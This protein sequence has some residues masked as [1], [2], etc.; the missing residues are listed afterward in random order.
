MQNRTFRI[1]FVATLL[2]TP[3]PGQTDESETL[4]EYAMHRTDGPMKMDG[5][6]DEPAWLAAPVMSPF[7]FPWYKEGRK[8]QSV[9]KMLWDDEYVYIGHICEDAHITA[10]TEEHD[11]PVSKDDC[12]EIMVTPDP[13][14]PIFYFNVEWNVIGGYVDGHRPDGPKKPRVAWDVE[15]ARISGS[16]KGTIND[17]SDIDSWWIGEVAIPHS[18][19]AEHMPQ[20]PPKPGVEWRINLNRH[21]GD[22]NMQYSQW[23][24]G[25]TPQPAFHV[26][27]RFGV[28]RFSAAVSPFRT[29]K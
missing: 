14:K 7:H 3:V 18:N 9:V 12:F 8:E 24:P 6:L 23:S 11:G 22:T 16:L 13:A 19:F 25:D 29:V 20:F 15:G 10:R 21:G 2:C 4:P 27:H 26:P 1:A 28:L 17:D 5:R